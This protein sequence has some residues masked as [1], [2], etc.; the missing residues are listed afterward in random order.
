VDEVLAALLA[1]D[2]PARWAHVYTYAQHFH[3]PRP[4]S[5]RQWPW[6]TSPRPAQWQQTFHCDDREALQTGSS[7]P[8]GKSIKGSW[9]VDRLQDVPHAVQWLD[10]GHDGVKSACDLHKMLM[11]RPMISQ[12]RHR[13]RRIASGRENS[14]LS[15]AASS[16]AAKWAR[17]GPPEASAATMIIAAARDAAKAALAELL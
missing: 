1:G 17:H 11:L 13:L 12:L 16:G 5:L 4:G 8:R 10:Q 15:T 2:L 3:H 7:E 9:L 14:L 6:L